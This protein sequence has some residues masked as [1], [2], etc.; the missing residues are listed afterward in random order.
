MSF[1][2][3]QLKVRITW[4]CVI[5]SMKHTPPR[6]H[7]PQSFSRMVGLVICFPVSW[8]G[9]YGVWPRDQSRL[10]S[11][12]AIYVFLLSWFLFEYISLLH[13]FW[14]SQFLIVS[15]LSS[16]FSELG[17]KKNPYIKASDN[18]TAAYTTV[19][20]P[21]PCVMFWVGLIV[22]YVWTSGEEE[23]G[24]QGVRCM[25]WRNEVGVQGGLQVELIQDPSGS[26]HGDVRLPLRDNL[27]RIAWGTGHG[28][29]H[30]WSLHYL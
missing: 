13:S 9:V 27:I 1:L 8:S 25:N 21:F 24:Q 12:T 11:P 5:L 3:V 17:E 19:V 16:L 30:G 23:E 4:V 10:Q 18:S 14:L 15:S 2:D 29:A 22:R 6:S 7:H 26:Q 20:V 28:W